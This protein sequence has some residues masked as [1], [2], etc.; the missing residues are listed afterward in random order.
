MTQFPNSKT[1]YIVGG[2]AI[3]NRRNVYS[4]SFE[5]R[6]KEWDSFSMH[7]RFIDATQLKDLKHQRYLH[8]TCPIVLDTSNYLLVTGGT[9]EDGKS[10]EL[11]SCA[12][13]N[14]FVMPSLND[15]RSRHSA[16]SMKS[17][18]NLDKC[19]VFSHCTI[20][21]LVVNTKWKF[22]ASAQKQWI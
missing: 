14:S 17:M 20:E 1:V 3:N 10:V 19:F 4:L 8:A 11:Y 22:V 2:G 7:K 21:Y 12:T 9:Y 15:A 13:Q 6:V 18:S 16:V 5:K